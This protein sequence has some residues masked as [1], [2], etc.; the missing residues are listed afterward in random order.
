[1]D[2]LCCFAE[3]KYAT[4][5]QKKIIWTVYYQKTVKSF[6]PVMSFVY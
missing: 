1:M 6:F 2:D 3:K 4:K 5:V